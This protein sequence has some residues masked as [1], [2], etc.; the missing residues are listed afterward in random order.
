MKKI[1]AQDKA[2]TLIEL[3]IVITIM[4]VLAGAA[5]VNVT[6][7]YQNQGTLDDSKSVVSELRS[8]YSK[9]TS[10]FYPP[11]CDN[12]TSYTVEMTTGGKDMVVTANCGSPIKEIKLGVLKTTKFGGNYTVVINVS[13]G[14]VSK[15]VDIEIL[16]DSNEDVV[17]TIRVRSYGVFEILSDSTEESMGTP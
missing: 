14:S 13:S 15:N 9:A 5:I 10:V 6:S 16:N 11:G 7:F 3:V 1:S 8:V 12:L 4:I 2:F 17:K